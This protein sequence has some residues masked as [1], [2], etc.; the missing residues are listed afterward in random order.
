MDPSDSASAGTVQSYTASL[1]TVLGYAQAL[2]SE[3]V[4]LPA[5][6]GRT[7]AATVRA[8]LDDPPMDRAA[9]DG[10][11]LRSVDTQSAS[12]HTPRLLHC[13]GTLRAGGV[14]EDTLEAGACLRVMTGA[15][16]PAGADAVLPWEDAC[17]DTQLA[18]LKVF[19]PLRTGTHMTLRAA[20]RSRGEVLLPAGVRM[21][22]NALGLLA[23]QGLRRVRVRKCPRVALLALGDE[24]LLPGEPLKAG[25]IYVSNLYVLGASLR[26][27]GAEPI[28]LGVVQDHPQRIV[29]RLRHW[30]GAE[31]EA[32][33]SST[34][35]PQCELV[36][37]LGGSHHGEADFAAAVLEHFGT[38]LHFRRTRLHMGGSM[39]F[40][41]RGAQLW[42]GLPGTPVASWIAFQV[43]VR[44][45]LSALLGRRTRFAPCVWAQLSES[46]QVSPGAQ[47]F[48]P[49]RFLYADSTADSTAVV[50][51][52]SEEEL[53]LWVHG[54]TR[55]AP[56]GAQEQ[57]P[58]A[59]EAPAALPMLK[60]QPLVRLAAPALAAN[61][62]I[63]IGAQGAS[64]P[65]GTVV[66]AL[67]LNA[68]E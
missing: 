11:A 5:A 23:S 47:R 58:E 15:A 43:F 24:L 4:A 14:Y 6:D 53:P 3:E 2:G 56:E 26:R 48:L 21:D 42:F 35:N 29:E 32:R 31:P 62:L 16:L 28:D 38:Q 46:V 9:M 65:A 66:S 25:Q 19:K 37:T 67:C 17:F 45:A 49:A 7:L 12:A 34:A 20:R 59:A 1:R 39:L 41:T 60:L 68:W 64:W 50:D 8:V 57:A 61:A 27:C 51:A 63:P 33:T 52:S 40:A 44:P 36:I 10:Y 30:V 54:T 22:P 18:I 13:V 55:N